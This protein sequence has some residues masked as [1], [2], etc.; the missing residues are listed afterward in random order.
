MLSQITSDVV[1]LLLIHIM[2]THLMIAHARKVGQIKL[3][4]AAIVYSL[5]VPD[6]HWAIRLSIGGAFVYAGE[7]KVVTT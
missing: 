4:F 7:F 5:F 6:Y 3:I 2:E 1:A